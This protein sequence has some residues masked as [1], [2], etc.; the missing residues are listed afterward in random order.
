MFGSPLLLGVPPHSAGCPVRRE[1]IGPAS[2]PVVP[3]PM[4]L[5]G[6]AS[7]L[8]TEGKNGRHHLDHQVNGQMGEKLLTLVRNCAQCSKH[9]HLKCDGQDSPSVR[10]QILPVYAA[11]AFKRWNVSNQTCGRNKVI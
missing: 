11:R 2:Q 5:A 6:H 7:R 8:K 1:V 10:K 3:C 9:M 4:D